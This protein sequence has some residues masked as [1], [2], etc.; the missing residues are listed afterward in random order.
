MIRVTVEIVGREDE[1]PTDPPLAQILLWNRLEG[2]DRVDLG[3][4]GCRVHHRDGRRVPY[5]LGHVTRHSSIVR[6]LA[7][8]FD[9]MKH[10]EIANQVM[11]GTPDPY[12]D[13]APCDVIDDALVPE[14]DDPEK[15]KAWWNKV[16]GG[17]D[18]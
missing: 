15:V 16:Y 10:E 3:D 11:G 14:L 1:A 8:I 6:F 18:G 2:G 17:G 7:G 13:P 9:R 5:F 4:Y 12:A